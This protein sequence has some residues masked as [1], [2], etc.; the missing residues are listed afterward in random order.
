MKVDSGGGTNRAPT[1]GSGAPRAAGFDSNSV[2]RRRENVYTCQ[3]CK[4][5]TVTIDVDEGTTPFM[6]RCR[7]QDLPGLGPVCKG[8]AYSSFYPKGPRPAHIPAPEWEWYRPDDDETSKCNAATKEHIRMGGL[9]L[10][11]RQPESAVAP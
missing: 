10:R 11:R 8:D 4:G 6:I 1:T 2:P 9:L 5:L 3:K 7:A